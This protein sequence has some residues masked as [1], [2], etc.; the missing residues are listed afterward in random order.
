ML[1]YEGQPLAV[2][3]H[4]RLREV[5]I[6]GGASSLRE[7]VAV[8]RTLYDYALRLLGELRWTGLAMVEFKV[9]ADGPKLMEINGRVWGSL[10][11]AVHS[12]VNFPVALAEL[13]L[14]G[15]PR[16]RVTQTKY[17]LGVR[18]RNLELDVMWM[19]AVLVG[20]QRYP[21][22]PQ[23]KRSAALAAFFGL[24]NPRTRFDILS[25][26]DPLPGLAELL[27]IAGKLLKKSRESSQ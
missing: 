21:F 11:L 4:K 17:R 8:D 13:Y 14:Q 15:P 5:P 27:R 1:T 20:R 16:D 22:L 23:P 2:F 12:G 18:G 24:L 19:I 3:Q 6:T 26:R 25:L 10:P 7:S 9:G